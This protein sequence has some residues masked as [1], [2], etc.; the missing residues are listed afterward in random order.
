MSE[1]VLCFSLKAKARIAHLASTAGNEHA[2]AQVL[3]GPWLLAALGKGCVVVHGY[4]E[5]RVYGDIFAIFVV[6]EHFVDR[7]AGRAD[8]VGH[9]TLR[10]A[11]RYI[12]GA[13]VR[14]LTV[15]LGEGEDLAGH[16]PIYVQGRQRLYLRIGQAQP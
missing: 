11:Y 1:I 7:H 8:H 14:G 2:W 13:A 3:S 9:I 10:E 5:R 12:H 15:L 16:P 4:A 6:D